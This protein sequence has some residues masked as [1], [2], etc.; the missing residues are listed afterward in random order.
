MKKYNRK[1]LLI[2]SDGTI[3][4]PTEVYKE[5]LPRKRKPDDKL[6]KKMYI[7]RTD[8]YSRLTNLLIRKIQKNH[9]LNSKT[10]GIVDGWDKSQWPLETGPVQILYSDEHNPDDIFGYVGEIV[11]IARKEFGNIITYVVNQDSHGNPEC[12]IV[13]GADESIDDVEYQ[14]GL[15]IEILLYINSS[16]HVLNKTGSAIISWNGGRNDLRLTHF[17]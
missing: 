6:L 10:H 2:S 7:V 8:L 15:V 13:I 1:R 16:V 5:P 4:S 12:T 3:D 11:K 14:F 17:L 9:N